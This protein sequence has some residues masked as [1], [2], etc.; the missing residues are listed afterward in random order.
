MLHKTNFGCEISV[1]IIRD[2]ET[3]TARVKVHAPIYKNKL[4]T[5]PH[6]YKSSQFSDFQILHDSDFIRVM[7]KYYP[8]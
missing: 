6:S 3:D 7:F 1:E 8:K 2:S 4:W 5:M